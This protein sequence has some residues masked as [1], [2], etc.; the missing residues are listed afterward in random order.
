LRVWLSCP[1]WR[2]ARHVESG[3]ER[4]AAQADHAEGRA[5]HV[6][7]AHRLPEADE[8]A[9]A[10]RVA[11]VADRRGRIADVV[12]DR[13]T[14]ID[15]E[16]MV[17]GNRQLQQMSVIGFMKRPWQ[18]GPAAAGLRS[19]ASSQGRAEHASDAASLVAG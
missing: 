13:R 15:A 19:S 14:A 2:A 18:V 6:H 5:R 7:H 9:D 12:A 3:V 4:D 11:A 10:G 1:T 8:H 17:S 16:P